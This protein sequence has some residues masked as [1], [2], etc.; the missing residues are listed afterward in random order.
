MASVAPLP[1]GLPV[2]VFAIQISYTI[3]LPEGTLVT[4]ML[5]RP[6]VF[7]IVIHQFGIA[8]SAFEVKADVCLRRKGGKGMGAETTRL[9]PVGCPDNGC[10]AWIPL[11]N[12]VNTVFTHSGFT[13]GR[14]FHGC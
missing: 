14:F 13:E 4:Q 9:F 3:I 8:I 6:I 11:G 2:F 7:Y 12:E 10:V 5:F 1:L